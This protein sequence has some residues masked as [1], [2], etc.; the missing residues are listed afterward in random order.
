[1]AIKTSVK[2]RT[3]DQVSTV[4]FGTGID[5]VRAL[6]RTGGKRPAVIILHE[7]YGVDRH[8][9]DLTAKLARAGF[10]G[11]APDLFH[12]FTGDRKTVLRG[13][14]RVDLTDDGAAE[15]L[16]AAVE[17]LQKLKSVDASRIGIIGVCQTGRQ[18]LL[19]AAKR[20]DIACAVVLY[21]AIGG[22][23][24]QPN[25]LRP[26]PI[27]ALIAEIACPVLGIFGE[28]DHIISVDDVVRFRNCLEK[29]GKSYHVRLYRDAPHGWLN[30]TMPG[31]Y[32]REAAKDAWSLM[33]AFLKKCFVGGWNPA[34]IAWTFESDHSAQYDFARNV[35]LE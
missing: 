11:L 29:A 3:G 28:A 22:R 8:T 4:Q 30:D 21:G 15:D 26:T 14:Q 32:R 17:Y 2:T 18:P 24:W 20:S 1:M 5:A 12:R 34:R 27:E 33:T 9:R 16:N 13:E 7:R 6:P 23:E 25:E 31:R 35:R 10:V 19:L